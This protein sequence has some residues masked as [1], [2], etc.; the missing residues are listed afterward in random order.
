MY[1]VVSECMYSLLRVCVCMYKHDVCKLC[2]C[3]IHTVCMHSMMCVC[4]CHVRAY[5]FLAHC[6]CVYV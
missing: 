1:H 2:V 5:V 3:A 6:E 4:V